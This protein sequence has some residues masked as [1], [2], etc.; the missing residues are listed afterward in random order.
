MIDRC[1]TDGLKL[2]A[3]D[4]EIQH[5]EGCRPAGKNCVSESWCQ[6]APKQATELFVLKRDAYTYRLNDEAKLVPRV[7]QVQCSGLNS[8]MTTRTRTLR[9][10]R[11]PDGRF[12]TEGPMPMNTILGV[13]SSLSQAIGS[14]VCE[15]TALSRDQRCRVVIAVQQPNG[16]F[17]QDQIINPPVH[18]RKKPRPA[19]STSASI[20]CDPSANSRQN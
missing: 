8:L 1:Q 10:L 6:N 18:I 7:E 14:A 19:N 16:R 2:F 3:C 13:D 20:Q 4:F 15:A 9:I 11:R 17:Q 12:V 5:F